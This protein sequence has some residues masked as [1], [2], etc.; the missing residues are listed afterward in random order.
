MRRFTLLCLLLLATI[1]AMWSQTAT[2]PSTGDGTEGNPYEIANIEN[3]YWLTQTSS[4][5]GA[6]FIQT[7]D[8]DAAGSDS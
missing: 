7:A 2:A 3:L 1:T 6:Y 5:W 4:E 8:I